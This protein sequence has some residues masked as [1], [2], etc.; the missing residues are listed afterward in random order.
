[1]SEQV[2]VHIIKSNNWIWSPGPAWWRERTG[3]LAATYYT[4][5]HVHAHTHTEQMN[6]CNK[7]EKV[8]NDNAKNE[9]KSLK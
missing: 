4:M 5:I 1:M 6:K 9:D 8:M 3:L 7:V 2:K